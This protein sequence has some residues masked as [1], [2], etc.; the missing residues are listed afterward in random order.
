MSISRLASNEHLTYAPVQNTNLYMTGVLL[1]GAL[2]EQ[3]FYMKHY[4][5]L[6]LYII[7]LLYIHMCTCCAYA[8][9]VHMQL[10]FLFCAA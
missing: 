9:H 5:L 2:H 4:I 7:I 6:L 8:V 1:V 10:Y 3:Q